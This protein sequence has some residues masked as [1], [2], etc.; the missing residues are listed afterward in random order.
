M[1]GD[2]MEQEEEEGGQDKDDKVEQERQEEDN[3]PLNDDSFG[4]GD[5][6]HGYDEPI[7]DNLLII[8][9]NRYSDSPNNST[10]NESG[11]EDNLDDIIMGAGEVTLPI[12]YQNED[13]DCIIR[14]FFHL[15][16]KEKL[17]LKL[18]KKCLKDT[19]YTSM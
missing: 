14:D 11:I 10:D 6:C 5:E 16:I 4:D 8:S 7:I 18:L 12:E 15:Q 3:L 9:D 1:S 13:N 17:Y 19:M 2:T